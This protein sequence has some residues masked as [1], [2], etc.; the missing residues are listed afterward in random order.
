MQTLCAISHFDFNLAGA[1]SYEDAFE[2]MRALGLSYPELDQLYK[3]MVFNVIARNQDDHTK[4]IA[5]LMDKKGA[6]QLS[7]AYDVTWNYNPRGEWTNV[8]QMSINQKRDN[9][10]MNDLV[11][12]AHRQ[13]IKNYKES[14]EQ[15]ID[16][17]SRWQYFAGETG[18]QKDMTKAARLSH[19]LKL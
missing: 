7:P 14:I 13:G 18:V 1:Y 12:V 3:R 11:E 17:V 15:I 5:F 10:I 9:F 8:H 2:E 4:N 16:T 19:R 6:W